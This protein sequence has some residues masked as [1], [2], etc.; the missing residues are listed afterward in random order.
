MC[1]LGDLHEKLKEEADKAE[2]F[3]Q[4]ALKDCK[5]FE[6]CKGDFG[7]VLLECDTLTALLKQELD[8]V[9][10]TCTLHSAACNLLKSHL[11]LSRNTIKGQTSLRGHLCPPC[12]CAC[13]FQ[14]NPTK[15]VLTTHVQV[16]ALKT[17]ETQ[18]RD[19]LSRSTPSNSSAAEEAKSED[20]RTV[21]LRNL[22]AEGDQQHAIHLCVLETL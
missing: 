17:F 14:P 7:T 21:E 22:A 11:T 13:R 12:A 19:V 5:G 8:Q 4:K 20:E 2:S 10:Q 15:H 3:L 18:A 16:K 1:S 9:S 6:E